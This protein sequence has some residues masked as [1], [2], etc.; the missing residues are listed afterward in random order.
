MAQVKWV[1]WALIGA[2]VALLGATLALL[3]WPRPVPVADAALTIG[4]IA[5][6]VAVEA[7]P[8]CARPI[9]LGAGIRAS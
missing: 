7:A 4:P 6:A 9:R 1:K 8:A 5:D 3:L 2:A